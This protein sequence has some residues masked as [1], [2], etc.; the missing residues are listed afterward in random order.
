MNIKDSLMRRQIF[1]QLFSSS[2]ADN[3]NSLLDD[4]F[5]TIT[6]RILDSS[7]EFEMQTLAMFRNRLNKSL[8]NGFREI[9]LQLT[10]R[11]LKYAEDEAV[12]S[13]SA[14]QSGMT[15]IM[16]TPSIK[17]IKKRVMN[18]GM[19]ILVKP[20]TITIT[21]AIDS[22]AAKKVFDINQIIN[23][24]IL[25]GKSAKDIVDN[26]N[27]ALNTRFKQQMTTLVKTAISHTAA[28]VRNV[29]AVENSNLLVGEEWVSTLH[30]AS[31][32]CSDRD[33]VI[34]KVGKGQ[35]PPAHWNCLSL[36]VPIVI[37]EYA[38]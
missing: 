3:A 10:D 12:F 34:Y 26:L 27:T 4:L 1:I 7:D 35:Q 19:D 32:V 14:V 17:L 18:S 13:L 15:A 29:N 25:E 2:E 23:D 30:N 36:R 22:F 20:G 5:N 28:V 33:G 38:I 9:K 11:I 31:K 16:L 6:D 24:G 37:D 8:F 21:E